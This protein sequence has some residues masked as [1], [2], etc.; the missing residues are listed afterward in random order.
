MTRMEKTLRFHMSNTGY[1]SD[2]IDRH[3]GDRN[4]DEVGI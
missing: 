1:P 2:M 3:G 4:Q